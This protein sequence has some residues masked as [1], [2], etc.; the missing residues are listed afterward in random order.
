MSELSNFLGVYNAMIGTV[1]VI[2]QANIAKELREQK[3]NELRYQLE[4]ARAQHQLDHILINNP[5]GSRVILLE[6]VVARD[7]ET[8]DMLLSQFNANPNVKD[9]NGNTAL[10]TAASYGDYYIV[11]LLIEYGA[12]VN[13]V[14]IQGNTPIHVA[15]MYGTTNIVNLL[16]GNGGDVNTCN[17]NGETPLFIAIKNNNY[18]MANSLMRYGADIN[19]QDSNGNSPLHVAAMRYNSNMLK[20]LVKFNADVNIE[21]NNGRTPLHFAVTSNRPYNV[22][23]LLSSESHSIIA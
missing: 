4:R 22:K 11:K 7:I 1:A 6:T 21:N 5:R 8:V 10:H 17:Y 2:Q 3:R 13:A 12:D 18:T 19:V 15:A 14:N 16:L 9:I 23:E 20:L